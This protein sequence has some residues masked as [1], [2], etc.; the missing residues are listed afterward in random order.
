MLSLIESY[1]SV[2]MLFGFS[3]AVLGIYLLI[4]NK[5][6]PFS[7]NM[8]ALLLFAW[9]FSCYWF[10]AF[11]V[12][13]HSHLFSVT[14]TT[15]IGPMLALTLFPPVF[16]YAKYVFYEYRRFQKKDHLHFLPIYGYLLFTIYLYIDS[17]FSV[18]NMRH[19]ELFSARRLGCAYVAT[20]QGPFY[21]LK[22]RQILKKRQRLLKEQYSDI[23]SLN[24]VWFQNI[25][26]IFALVFI[27]GG[28]STLV[29]L[30]LR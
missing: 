28:V 20:L 4:K 10:F 22:T 25:N 3:Q 30:N 5:H 17:D 27:I 14:I 18:T 16:L 12:R 29:E 1:F 15:F 23:E 2:L 19:H 11:L 9:G 21:Y 8:L 26:F 24:L 7:N 13:G 6:R